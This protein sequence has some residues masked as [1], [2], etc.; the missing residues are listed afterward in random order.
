MKTY[1]FL[2][3]LNKK[4]IFFQMANPKW[5]LKTNYMLACSVCKYGLNPEPWNFVANDLADYIKI[6]PMVKHTMMI[7]IDFH[8]C[9]SL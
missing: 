7:T 5:D 2:R 6:S 3:L 4:D 8:L 1:F 9:F